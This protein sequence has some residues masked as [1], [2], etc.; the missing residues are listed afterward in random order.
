M[1]QGGEDATQAPPGIDMEDYVLKL[2]ERAASAS[3][4]KYCPVPPDYNPADYIKKTEIDLETACP[5]LPDL[6][7]YVLKSTIPPVQK[8]PACIC[9]KVKVSA[10]M[11]KECPKPK[12][13]CPKCEPCGVEQCR[14]VIQCASNEKQV[15]CPKCPAPMPCPEPPEKVCPSFNTESDIQC[16]APKPCPLPGSCPVIDAKAPESK[17]QYYGIEVVHERS[18][19]KLL[20]NYF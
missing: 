4:R 8:C 1:V 18:V 6:K 3:T 12:N 15:S 5:K 19:N 11:C 9:P 10:G 16:P 13:N 17:C 14:D 2:I 20:M 7:D